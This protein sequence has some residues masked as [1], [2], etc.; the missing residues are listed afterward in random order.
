MR[1]LELPESLGRWPKLVLNVV[2]VTLVAY[3]LASATV[4]LL[5]EPVLPTTNFTE[6][7]NKG[8]SKVSIPPL[9]Y[10]SPIWQRN[11][12]KAARPKPPQKAEKKPTIEELPLAQLDIRLIGTIYSDVEL[13]SRA[14]T[15]KG[16]SQNLLKVGDSVGGFKILEIQRR[17]IV[18][19][20]GKKRELLLIDKADKKIA[21]Q[22]SRSRS[23]LSRKVVKAQ[24]QDLDELS[25]DISLSP[26][27]RGKQKGLWVRRLRKGS[28]FGKAGLKLNDV[29]LSIAGTPVVGAN[30]VALFELLNEKRVAVDILRDGRPMQLVI[31]LS[32]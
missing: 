31:H 22:S 23:S 29:I 26:A 3:F 1:G 18:L 20:R 32:G 17:A 16:A 30:P 25:K 10:F 8:K 4:A 5:V 9:K 6:S 27:T 12:F 19:E 28:L 15:L 13:F 11:A 21:A 2:T 7:D 14:I 24:L